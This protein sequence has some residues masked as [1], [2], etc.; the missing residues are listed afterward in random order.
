MMQHV[1]TLNAGSSSIKFALFEIGTE[2]GECVR[3]QVEGLGAT[4]HLQAM[5]TGDSAVDRKL[6]AAQAHDHASAL[7]VVLEFL[8]QSFGKIALEAV[9]HRVVH[10]GIE[11]SEAVVLDEEKIARLERLNRLA[12][13]HQ[14]YNLS[15]IR[16]ALRAFPEALQVACFDTAFHR[17]HP[18]VDAVEKVGLYDS[19][20]VVPIWAE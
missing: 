15:G 2:L 18:W 10:G 13:L 4:P 1:L 5:K 14:P 16:A 6:T 3:G 9:G 8:E 19:P 12:P 11:F 7:G 20:P 17:S